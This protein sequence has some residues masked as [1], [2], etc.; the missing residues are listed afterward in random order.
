ME[1]LLEAVKQNQGGAVVNAARAIDKSGHLDYN[2]I[3]SIEQRKVNVAEAKKKFSELLGRVAFGKETIIVTKRGK[4][5]VEIIPFQKKKK[6]PADVKGWLD[7][8]DSFF[9]DIN[10]FRKTLPRILKTDNH[11]SS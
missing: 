7:N 11:V 9:K 3:M 1:G 10:L 6:H 2:Q 4:P 8:D 5:L